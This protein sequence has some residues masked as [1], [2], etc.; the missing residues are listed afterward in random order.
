MQLLELEAAARLG[1]SRT[2]VREAMVRL[3]QEGVVELRPRHGMRILPLSAAALAEIYEVTMALEGAAAETLARKGASDADIIAMRA[4]VADMEVALARDDLTA[5]SQADE[6]FHSLLVKAAGTP[7][8]LRGRSS[9]GAVP[10]GVHDDA[11]T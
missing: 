1:M 2:P 9:V 8:S 7:V 10:Q 5:W 11:S 6:R 3:E 4:A